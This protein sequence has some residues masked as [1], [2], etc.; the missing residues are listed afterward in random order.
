MC[1]TLEEHNGVDGLPCE[2]TYMRST[3]KIP[4]IM[5]LGQVKVHS[6]DYFN[7]EITYV[8]RDRLRYVGHNKW[9]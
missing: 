3:Q 1:L 6:G 2:G 7:G 8:S 5:T 9:L 4:D